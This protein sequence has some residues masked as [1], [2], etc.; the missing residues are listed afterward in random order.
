VTSL[1][2]DG[3]GALD[4]S[5]QRPGRFPSRGN[6]DGRKR[7]GRKA[8][9]RARRLLTLRSTD[10]SLSN[11]AC[12]KW[13]G[14]DLKIRSGQRG[15]AAAAA[16]RTRSVARQGQAKLS[17]QVAE[18]WLQAQV[19]EL[20]IRDGDYSHNAIL[21]RTLQVIERGNAVSNSSRAQGEVV[22]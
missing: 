4:S 22:R 19:I 9:F 5:I 6:L 12:L 21:K 17:K 16:N 14:L 8:T 10:G 11:V 1:E 15:L 3:V 20:G 7:I 2:L 13:D 18:P